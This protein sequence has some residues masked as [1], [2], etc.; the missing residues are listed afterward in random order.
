MDKVIFSAWNMWL[1]LFTAASYTNLTTFSSIPCCVAK[2]ASHKV[3]IPRTFKV[4][5][6][7]KISILCT[8]KEL[9]FVYSS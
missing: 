3:Y 6:G 2:K 5:L 1:F 9:C 8:E 7:C 4:A